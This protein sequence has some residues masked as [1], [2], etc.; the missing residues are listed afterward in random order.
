MKVREES[1]LFSSEYFPCMHAYT[2]DT[3]QEDPKQTRLEVLQRMRSVVR[4]ME[5]G[6][7]QEQM[8]EYLELTMSSTK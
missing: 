3:V 6:F 2:T 8:L 4:L 5:W 1:M 7:T